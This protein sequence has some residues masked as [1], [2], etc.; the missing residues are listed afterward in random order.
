[1]NKV[2]LVGNLT[3]D[4]ES[5]VTSPGGVQG[6]HFTIAVTRN[7]LSAT[8]ER[9]TDFFNITTWRGV[10]ENVCKYTKKGSKVAV[11]GSIQMRSYEDNKGIKRTVV[12]VIAEE[13]E[14]LSKSAASN[15]AESKPNLQR[16]A[17]DTDVPF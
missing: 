10:A 1:M 15:Q 5:F 17:D 16:L 4:P 11:N 3:K 2:F 13:V 9:I 8:N 7:Y 14:F 12:D 6:C